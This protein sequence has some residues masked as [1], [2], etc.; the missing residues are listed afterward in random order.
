MTSWVA[1][2]RD[3]AADSEVMESFKSSTGKVI[4]GRDTRSRNLDRLLIGKSTVTG[5][6]VRGTNK[7]VLVVIAIIDVS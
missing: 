4:K 5:C 3:A 6:L 7:S 2:P 1:N